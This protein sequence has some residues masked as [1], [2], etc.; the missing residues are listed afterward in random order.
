MK[1]ID[2]I[3]IGIIILL[4]IGLVN[5]TLFIIATVAFFIALLIIRQIDWL[6]DKLIDK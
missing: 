4:I 5:K 1:E 6:F 3:Y 2:L